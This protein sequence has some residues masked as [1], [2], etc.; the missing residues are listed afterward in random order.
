MIALCC[1]ASDPVSLIM[2][3]TMRSRT[4]KRDRTRQ[5]AASVYLTAYTSVICVNWNGFIVIEQRW[6]VRAE[7][8]PR[9]K[10]SVASK[11]EEKEKDERKFFFLF[12][13]IQRIRKS[14]RSFE[15]YLKGTASNFY[16]K[17]SIKIMIRNE[18]VQYISWGDRIWY[19]QRVGDIFRREKRFARQGKR[20]KK[21]LGE[22]ESIRQIVLLSFSLLFNQPRALTR[23]HPQ[24]ERYASLLCSHPCE[25]KGA[26][27]SRL[28][29]R[30]IACTFHARAC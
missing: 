28:F 17:Y 12:K 18:N 13:L 20:G 27:S 6:H 26:E 10:G 24:E 5:L 22:E 3:R 9:S 30:G 11:K 2:P 4:T 21:G 29:S 16:E 25:P 1:A 7:S 23:F 15:L 19:P 8:Q 14:F